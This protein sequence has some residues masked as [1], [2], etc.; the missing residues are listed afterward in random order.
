MTDM[1]RLLEERKNKLKMTEVRLEK[2]S[3]VVE[4]V[5]NI[6]DKK[7]RRANLVEQ[8][9]DEVLAFETNQKQN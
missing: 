7:V 9:R 4:K 5:N 1:M 3:V 2:K 8:Q 6:L